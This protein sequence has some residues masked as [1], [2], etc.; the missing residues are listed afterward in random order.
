MKYCLDEDISPKVAEL[1]RRNRIEAVSAH[2]KGLLGASDEGQLMMAAKD[3][4]VQ[5][6]V[7]WQD[8]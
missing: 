1:L 4:R 7:Y 8:S 3:S 6:L 5:I 2:K